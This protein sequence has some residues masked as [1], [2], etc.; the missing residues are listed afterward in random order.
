M[1][2]ASVEEIPVDKKHIVRKSFENRPAP[3]EPEVIETAEIV[4]TES[5]PE[6]C[7][8]VKIVTRYFLKSA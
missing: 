4:H 6:G 1:A 5:C 2:F 7:C 3:D 8:D